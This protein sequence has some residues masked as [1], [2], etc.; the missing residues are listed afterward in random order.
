[1][2]TPVLIKIFFWVSLVLILIIGIIIMISGV[3]TAFG[4]YGTFM[5]AVGGLI[6]GPLFIIMGA[7]SARIY[8]ELLILFFQMNETLTDVKN[9]L[10]QR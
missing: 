1:M 3:V 7:L 4:R 2:I 10:E 9:L 5:N 8:A 6:G